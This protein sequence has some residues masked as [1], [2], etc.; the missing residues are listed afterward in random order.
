M[1]HSERQNNLRGWSDDEP[2]NVELLRDIGDGTVILCDDDF[3]ENDVVT[4]WIHADADL[5][6]DLREVA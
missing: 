6:K 4:G 2:V 3:T 1:A 5:L